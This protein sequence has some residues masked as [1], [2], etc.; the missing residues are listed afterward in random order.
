MEQLALYFPCVQSVTLWLDCEPLKDKDVSSEATWACG[1]YSEKIFQIELQFFKLNITSEKKL[2]AADTAIRNTA[3]IHTAC[4][5]IG[6]P[7]P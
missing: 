5:Q 4:I 1:R 3:L 2:Q 6:P 7:P